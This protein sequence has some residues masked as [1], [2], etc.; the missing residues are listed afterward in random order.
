MQGGPFCVMA[1]AGATGVDKVF[2][3][4]GPARASRGDAVVGE[5]AAMTHIDPMQPAA[6]DRLGASLA[7][8]RQRLA[9]CLCLELIFLHSLPALPARNIHVR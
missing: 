8:L 7:W 1:N 4:T 5:L 9:A 2:S 3:V 6:N